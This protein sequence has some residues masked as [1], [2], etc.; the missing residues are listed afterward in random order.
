MSTVNSK[1][2]HHPL[3][4]L[5]TVLQY[6]HTSNHR[7]V[8]YIDHFINYLTTHLSSSSSSIIHPPLRILSDLLTHHIHIIEHFI[9]YIHQRWIQRHHNT[10]SQPSSIATSTSLRY[11][12]IARV[13]VYTSYS[14]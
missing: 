11:H 12:S 13:I 4:L 1:K 9:R 2:Q 8:H 6:I 7:I 10:I 5:P 3:T 14:T